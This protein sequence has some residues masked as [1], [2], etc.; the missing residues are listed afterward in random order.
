VSYYLNRLVGELHVS[1]S[2]REVI[3]HVRRT[4]RTT[5]LTDRRLREARH[6]LYRDAL[7]VHKANRDLF[8]AVAR[9]EVG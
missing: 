7:G 8:V 1:A 3:R 4:L 9:G 5:A 2:P 6:S